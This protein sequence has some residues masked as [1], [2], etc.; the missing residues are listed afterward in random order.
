MMCCNRRVWRMLQLYS[1]VILSA[2]TVSQEIESR[3]LSIGIKRPTSFPMYL[4]VNYKVLNANSSFFLKEANQDIMRNSSMQTHTE[5]FL[6]LQASQAQ[7]PIVNVSYGPLSVEQTVPLDMIQMADLFYTT[8]QFSFNWKI[9]SYILNRRVSSSQP[10]VQVLFYISGN[11]WYDQSPEG[12]MDKLPCIMVFAFWQTQEVRGSCRLQG[13]LGLCVAELEPL[14]SWF[15]PTGETFNQEKPVDPADGT[16]VELYY[17]IRSTLNGGCVNEEAT[18]RG[19]TE[20][21]EFDETP[22]TPMRRI[23]SV[24]IHQIPPSEGQQAELRLGDGVVIQVSSKPIKKRD[25]VTF[26]VSVSPGSTVDAFTLRAKVKKGFSFRNVRISNSPAWEINLEIGKDGKYGTTTV[27]CNRKSSLIANRSESSLLEIMQLDFEANELSSQSDSLG[28]TWQVELPGTGQA[29]E[30]GETELYVMQ[31]EIIGIAPLA[32]DTEILNM[33][34]LTGKRVVV[35]VKVVALERDGTVT[36]VSDFTDC[37]STDDEVLKVSDRCDYVYVNGKE[38][39]GKV[40]MAVNFTYEYLSAQLEMTVWIPR[41][42]LQ[43]EVSDTELS[44]IKGWRVPVAN[45]RPSWDSDDEDE[46]DRKGRG[47]TLQ[48][49]HAMVRVFTHFVAEQSDP[50]EQ[51]TYFLGPDWQLDITEL[52][53]YFLK[54]ENPRIAR[55]QDGKILV[56]RDI[57]VTTIQVLSPLSDSIL[58]EKTVTVLDDKVTITDLGVQL[59]TGLSL[60]LQL[61]TESNRA[62]VATTTT[63]E[64]LHSPKQEAVISVWIQFSDGSM[65][66]LD[67]YDPSYF[68]LAVTS[69]DKEVVSVR[70]DPQMNTPVVVAEGEGQGDLVKVEMVISEVCQKSKRKSTLSVG[71]GSLKVKFAPIDNRAKVGSSSDYG[72]DGKEVENKESVRQQKTGTEG[73]YYGSSASDRKESAMRKITTT[74]KSVNSDLDRGSISSNVGRGH[75]N[76]VNYTNFPSQVD[77]SN[78][79]GAVKENELAQSPRVLTDLEIGMYALLGVFCLAILVFLLN[80]VSY[81]LK[82]RH[83]QA[84]VQ[85]QENMNHMH[86]WVWLGTDAELVMNMADAPAQHDKHSTTVIDIALGLENGANLVSGTLQKTEQGHILGSM[87]SLRTKLKSESINSPTTKRKSVKFTT[88][89]SISVDS[90]RPSAEAMLMDHED[91][92]WVS[93]ELEGVN[94]K[95][96]E[97]IEKDQLDHL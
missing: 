63:Q 67:I 4:L 76:L 20:Q 96:Q 71:N 35:P 37:R 23:G 11:N 12:T 92:K 43:I 59:V 8:N 46:D 9:Q 78:N 17:M 45:K 57:G 41:L 49:Q 52:V 2:V 97:H 85:G 29:A 15:S 88:F 26:Y 28:I 10:K 21:Y 3:E 65:T 44:Q 82:F 33:A 94:S 5:P 68:T 13:N 30:E 27:L 62:I 39:K 25:V 83:K 74:A 32:M 86:D 47:C 60:S 53:T 79:R 72:N 31:K 42:P 70:K 84:S 38:M 80:C 1:A 19:R 69:L 36:D 50:R 24:H 75:G 7:A 40:K 58:A 51:L 55:L 89:T 87:S 95:D 90:V 64:L 91:I 16:P 81:M 73:R 6:I 48:Y 18:K 22:V 34:L 77:I 14:S 56:G 93:K 61:S 66:P 54:V